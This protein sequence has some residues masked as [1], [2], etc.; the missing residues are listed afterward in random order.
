MS[1]IDRARPAGTLYVVGTPIGNLAEGSP[2]M[3]DAFERASAVLCEDTRV[4]GK[5]LLAWGI[6]KPLERADAKRLP[7]RAHGIVSRLLSGETLALASDAG[8]PAISDPGQLLVDAALDAGVR[9][10]V[11][12]GPSALT[13]AVAA[14]G[15]QCSRFTFLGFLAR[16]GRAR[17]EE[18]QLVASSRVGAVIYESPHRVRATLADLARVLPGRRVALCRELTKLHQEVLR[19][20]AAELEEAL[21][22]REEERGALKGECVFVVEM[23]SLDERAHEAPRAEELSKRAAKLLEE[24][25]SASK[26]AK[27]LARE[28]GIERDAAYATVLML[29]GD[30]SGTSGRA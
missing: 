26:A 23:P 6:S 1:K 4:T 30:A 16:K 12:A 17:E 7:E 19:G 20:T 22:A 8:M 10:E 9:V 25:L 11:V 28:R 2:A 13:A 5:L 18:L 27:A 15:L 21:R 3:R 29:K 14:S 24:G